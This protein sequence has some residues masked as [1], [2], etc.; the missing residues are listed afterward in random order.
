M[1]NGLGGNAFTRNIG[2]D[3]DPRSRSHEA[4]PSTSCDL[5]TCSLKLLRPIV[6]E[7]HYQENTLYDLE[8]NDEGVKVTRNATSCDLCT[9]KV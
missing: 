6:K 9:S 4:L 8:S 1:S 3:I 2:F 7:M 5:C